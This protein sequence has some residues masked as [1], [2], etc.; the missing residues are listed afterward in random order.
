MEDD[1]LR[2]K[3]VPLAAEK[4]A[5]TQKGAHSRNWS[6]FLRAPLSYYTLFG[7]AA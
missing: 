4:A 6:K 5:L 7:N 2:I 1:R 3:L